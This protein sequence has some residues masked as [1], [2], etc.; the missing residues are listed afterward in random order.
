MTGTEIVVMQPANTFSVALLFG[1][2]D[3]TG[4][5]ARVEELHLPNPL[6][7][8]LLFDQ[9]AQQDITPAD[10]R[11]RVEL[12]APPTAPLRELMTLYVVLAG[13]WGRF[14]PV[15][16]AEGDLNLPDPN[17]HVTPP[18]PDPVPDR[19]R[20]AQDLESSDVSQLHHARRLE[21]PLDG[22]GTLA[23]LQLV[24]DVAAIRRRP[25]F[26]RLPDVFF[27]GEEVL[28]LE[29]LRR[30]G[31]AHRADV[32]RQAT[33]TTVDLADVGPRMRHLDRA[34][35][36]PI[37]DTLRRLGATTDESGERWHCTRPG[38]HTNGDQNPSLRIVAGRTRCFRCDP[39][40]VDS[41]RLVADTLDV[42]PDEAAEWLESGAAL[43]P[44]R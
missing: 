36:A 44:L 32:R 16:L 31:A 29:D 5:A 42:S 11:T 22:M 24:V 33:T 35:S 10:A 23:A 7:P 30:A 12:V 13:F 8:E 3:D 34:A 6:T 26:E 41:L 38:R 14:I 25:R 4:G 40:W 37:A 21:L 39:E 28:S 20:A 1:D 15:R 43:A 9:L 17:S 27:D 18:R 2:P 19:V